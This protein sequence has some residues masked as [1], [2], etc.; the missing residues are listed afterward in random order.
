MDRFQI[1]AEER[2]NRRIRKMLASEGFGELCSMLM[3]WGAN[4]ETL[5]VWARTRPRLIPWIEVNQPEAVDDAVAGLREWS[6]L[7]DTAIVTTVPGMPEIYDRIRVPGVQ[8]IPGVKTNDALDGFDDVVGWKLVSEDLSDMAQRCGSKRVVLECESA[9]GAY[10]LGKEALDWH[11]FRT[12]I[13]LLPK[14]LEIIWYPGITGNNPDKQTRMMNLCKAVV[15]EH[16]NTI[17]V[18]RT[19]GRPAAVKWH[20]SKEARKWLVVIGAPTIP[21][22]Y[23]Q[24]SDDYWRYDQIREALGHVINAPEV[25]IYPGAKDFEPAAIG[26]GKA[27]EVGG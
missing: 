16:A 8:I 20:W 18:D 2:D 6:K 17:L 13:R 3:N 4:E 22:Q 25:I 24:G 9:V 21:M 11:K 5:R 23:V 12:G 27:L 15:E 14:E 19:Y 10:G 1:L 26:I 7:T